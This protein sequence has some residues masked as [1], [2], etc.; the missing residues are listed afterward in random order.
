MDKNIFISSISFS[1]S[2]ISDIVKIAEQ[3]S[4]N[5]EFSS[6]LPYD[7][8]NIN[9]FNQFKKG[10]KLI[11][12]YFPAPKNSFVINLASSDKKIQQASIQHCISNLKVSAKNN[13]K[14]YAAHS[15]FCVDP[16]PDS[17]G[18]FIKFDKYYDRSNHIEI[19]LDS[20]K[21]ILSQ[22]NLL[23]VDFYIENNV[24][25][26][27][28]YVNNNYDNS[29]LCCTS[30]EI[31]YIFDIINDSRFGLLLDTA[32]LKVSSSTLNLDL[33]SEVNKVLNHIRAI[34]HSDNNGL[35]DS[36]NILTNDYWF[37]KFK[38]YFHLWDHVI[39]VKNINIKQIR[40]QISILQ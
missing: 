13:L 19:F 10:L 12:N 6:G 20:L 7:S 40:E 29:L 36:N 1:G 33:N 8:S 27:N 35:I 34:H 32:H 38:D 23:G 15:G 28:N 3:N 16:K 26:K 39:E 11:H 25:S 2:S 37:L 9:V 22:A 5:I 21:Q 31:N 4:L 17:L 18:G 30:D 14:F 24:I